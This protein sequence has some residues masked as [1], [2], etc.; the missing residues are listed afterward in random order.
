M[1][2]Q[3]SPDASAE[4]GARFLANVASMCANRPF[5][6]LGTG[7]NHPRGLLNLGLYFQLQPNESIITRL[8]RLF[9]GE[10]V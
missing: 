6:R 4:D 7:D 3:A 2:F 5:V 10:G 9:L 1:S 8:G